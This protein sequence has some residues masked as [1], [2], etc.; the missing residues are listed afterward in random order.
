MGLLE[1]TQLIKCHNKEE[2]LPWYSKIEK[3]VFLFL[4]SFKITVAEM[5]N[6][7]KNYAKNVSESQIDGVILWWNQGLI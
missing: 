5:S 2:Q 1:Q 4:F 3:K 6:K 7:G